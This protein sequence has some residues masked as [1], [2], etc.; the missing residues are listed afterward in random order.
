M[1]TLL[2]WRNGV[3]T[4]GIIFL[5]FIC[6][7]ILL[8]TFFSFIFAAESEYSK[9]SG[10]IQVISKSSPDSIGV[11]IKN[12][13]AP[14]VIKVDKFYRMEIAGLLSAA[15]PG[16]PVLPIQVIR[17]LVP[18]GKVIADFEIFTCDKI[19]LGGRYIVE[20][21]ITED[22]EGGV[23]VEPN[24][25]IYESSDP[26][27]ETVNKLV[28]INFKRGYKIAT[29]NIF[30][31]QYIPREGRVSYYNYFYLKIK[32]SPSE[33][34]DEAE[35]AIRGLES[36]REMIEKIV[37]NPQDIST[38]D[39]SYTE[40]IEDSE[41]A[42]G[43]FSSPTVL[44][45]NKIID[46]ADTC[47]YIIITN[48]KL[49]N[50]NV[51]TPDLPGD[52]T[53]LYSFNDLIRSKRD[54]G[55]TARIVTTEAIYTDSSYTGLRPD[56]RTDKATKVREFITDAYHNWGTEYVLL[57]GDGCAEG[58]ARTEDDIVVPVR[59]FFAPI[60]FF[61][62]SSVSIPSDLYYTCL[63][64]TMDGDF[65]GLYGEKDDPDLDLEAEVFVGR[66]PVNTASDVS[67]FVRKI[68]SY[69]ESTSAALDRACLLAGTIG[70]V[71]ETSGE[72]YE[73]SYMEQIRKGS[74]SEGLITKGFIDSGY[75]DI[76]TLYDKENYEWVN[77]DVMAEMNKGVHLIAHAGHSN[78]SSNLKMAYS[79]VDKL[80]N[81]DYFFVYTY[82]CFAGAFDNVEARDSIAEY[83]V[84]SEHGAF[85]YVA[86]SV[87]GRYDSSRLFQR[88]FWHVVFGERIFNIGRTLQYSKERALD[89]I[90]YPSGLHACY[91]LNLFGDPELSFK[92]KKASLDKF[93]II[94]SPTAGAVQD[95]VFE[96]HGDIAG[97]GLE[98][99]IIDYATD[100]DPES[101]YEIVRSYNAPVT[102]LLCECDASHLADGGITFRL[103]GFYSDGSVKE[104]RLFVI[105]DSAYITE[106]ARYRGG[107]ELYNCHDRIEIK[108]RAAGDGFK[109][110]TLSYAYNE[111]AE[112]E[113]SS[114]KIGAIE[115]INGGREPVEEGTLGYLYIEDTGIFKEGILTVRLDVYTDYGQKSEEVKIFVSPKLH[116]GWPLD[117]SLNIFSASVNGK[118]LLAGDY[119]V[120]GGLSLYSHDGN[121]I[122]SSYVNLGSMFFP[123]AGDL[124]GDGSDEMIISQSDNVPAAEINTAG[125]S[126][127]D[128]GLNLIN[129]ITDLS[130]RQNIC[131]IAQ[132][133]Y[134][135]DLEILTITN[136]GI[137]A[138]NSDGSTV[139]GEWPITLGGVNYN[140]ILSAGD[141]DRDGKDEVFFTCGRNLYG[142]DDNGTLLNNWPVEV[143]RD[144]NPSGTAGGE[145]YRLS[146]PLIGDLDGDGDVEIAVHILIHG[147]FYHPN[148]F[149][150][151]RNHIRVFSHEGILEYEKDW[152]VQPAWAAVPSS[153]KELIGADFNN[154]GRKELV[155]TDGEAI[156]ITNYN[157]TYYGDWPLETGISSS[158]LVA[159]VSGS[160]SPEVIFA[161]WDSSMSFTNIFAYDIDKNVAPGFPIKSPSVRD[162]MMVVQDVDGDL[163]NELIVCGGGLLAGIVDVDYKRYKDVYGATDYN[164]FIY[165]LE[166]WSA[167]NEDDTWPMFR[168][169]KHRTGSFISLGRPRTK[170]TVT[171]N[172][173]YRSSPVLVSGTV[174]GNGVTTVLVKAETLSGILSG[175]ILCYIESDG[176]FFGLL[177]L[178]D[179]IYKIT[180]LASDSSGVVVGSDQIR[181]EV[182]TGPLVNIAIPE[183]ETCFTKLPVIIEGTFSKGSSEIEGLNITV[184]GDNGSFRQYDGIT[185]IDNTFRYELNAIE[186]GI[187]TI[188]VTAHDSQGKTGSCSVSVTID[189]YPKIEIIS[190]R[191]GDVYNNLPLVSGIV[192][193]G[194]S[195]LKKLLVNG[196]EVQVE[197]NSFESELTDFHNGEN[198]VEVMAETEDGAIGLASV[199]F[200][201]ETE[202]TILQ[203]LY[204]SGIITGAD[205]AVCS[206]IDRKVL[207]E[208]G[209]A[210]TNDS[211]KAMFNLEEGIEYVLKITFHNLPG[212]TY[213]TEPFISPAIIKFDVSQ[214]RPAVPED[215]TL[216][217]N[218]YE[219]ENPIKNNLNQNEYARDQDEEARKYDYFYYQQMEYFV[220][221]SEVEA[222]REGEIT[223]V[224]LFSYDCTDEGSYIR[225]ISVINNYPIYRDISPYDCLAFKVKTTSGTEDFYIRIYYLKIDGNKRSTEFSEI[226]SGDFF[227]SS[228]V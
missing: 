38:Y 106:P 141:V 166:G 183:D 122:N 49:A 30:P 47:Q 128:S 121:L 197:G 1:C 175:E 136:K 4:H 116:Q 63:D 57:G 70:L 67:N 159:N 210:S 156:Y 177:G 202:S 180:A 176:Q 220:R 59:Y 52:I 168:H 46:P 6:S 71:G 54:K 51:E 25:S 190:P 93:A 123:A 142:I 11:L 158:I 127:F 65:D 16:E 189:V 94:K 151:K 161:T 172:N 131:T 119:S 86:N 8:D 169:D 7:I 92:I 99:F 104:D 225:Y 146:I 39:I 154:D 206:V 79:D 18:K 221:E 44:S 27:P 187:Q 195:K 62:D 3:F 14:R 58:R 200:T 164:V 196:K 148:T 205:V 147:T 215:N 115:L 182:A 74:D 174:Y 227:E 42:V 184:Q 129:E 213:Y 103:R 75:L 50:A 76:I 17:I 222:N 152:T 10:S 5:S 33:A 192:D 53:G 87:E 34:A 114:W 89:Y 20:P 2:K 110:Y 101:W 60:Y 134:D 118:I 149:S 144:I 13:P 224:K 162:N 139:D 223:G 97:G 218:D 170:I 117:R 130:I 113:P 12:I 211:G 32:L 125:I 22:S 191:E 55:L 28:R 188:T 83:F 48:E 84:T 69:E 112:E 226:Y 150:Y 181:I 109:N 178:A 45:E 138:F 155:F 203:L 31:V 137:G 185:F 208:Y 21:A 153:Q 216:M 140:T 37:D 186:N 160:A 66:A 108:G 163:K 77:T 9:S 133:G 201:I 68:L 35:A 40:F 120:V 217:I 19:E 72:Y 56:G 126:I 193:C 90:F 135:N 212:V 61:S 82:G 157:G 179:G 209:I 78:T 143:C 100:D 80:T 43:L 204:L 91:A 88:M 24:R 29:F 95:G 102:D 98:Y 107:L 219:D 23:H 145:N 173:I 64:G 105:I 228:K 132:L 165:D 167:Y 96:I 85:A 15:T 73:Y 41:S 194:D 198:T 81:T 199:R 26:Y 207:S 171:E 214:F 124:D 111:S 36:D